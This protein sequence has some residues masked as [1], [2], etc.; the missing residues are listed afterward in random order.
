MGAGSLAASPRPDV[1]EVR[2]R[3]GATH[4]AIFPVVIKD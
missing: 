1:V 2:E 3:D 4:R